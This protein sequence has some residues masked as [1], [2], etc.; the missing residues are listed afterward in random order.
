MVIPKT[1]KNH[2]GAYALISYLLRPDI[3][4]RNADYVWYA[5]P[6]KKALELIDEEARDDITLYP[7]DEMINKL[8]VFNDLGKETT[9]LY[10]DLF[11]DLKIAP[12][13]D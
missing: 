4:A 8:E 3:A 5:T 7:D 10:N 9:I 12:Q 1:S 11:L 2:D 6:N 13:A